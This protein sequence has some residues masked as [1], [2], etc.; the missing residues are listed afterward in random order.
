MVSRIWRL[1]YLGVCTLKQELGGPC[2]IA[3]H[4]ILRHNWG[5]VGGC[6]YLAHSRFFKVS[7]TLRRPLD[8]KGSMLS[9]SQASR[10]PGMQPKLNNSWY[11]YRK[12]YCKPCL[13]WLTIQMQ[14]CYYQMRGWI[15]CSCHIDVPLLGP[16]LRCYQIKPSKIQ[17][18]R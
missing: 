2:A 18:Q 9:C 3:T 6:I 12:M 14:S 17:Q 13:P 10:G 11:P 1:C 7:V 4:C 16:N 8:G 15:L 5:V